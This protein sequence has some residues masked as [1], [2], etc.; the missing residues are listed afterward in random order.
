MNMSK[1]KPTMTNQIIIHK[2]ALSDIFERN[3]EI[4]IEIA[5]SAKSTVAKRMADKFERKMFAELNSL[6]D[7]KITEQGGGWN[8]RKSLTQKTKDLVLSSAKEAIEDVIREE[9]KAIFEEKRVQLK[10]YI[11]FFVNDAV[12][13]QIDKI[14][15]IAI[16]NQ[17]GPIVQKEV[18]ERLGL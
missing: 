2:D 6:V 11:D 8:A 17:V 7:K 5:N 3:H 1:E 15:K 13:K 14:V 18:K 9:A 12:V 16:L 4:E 10:E